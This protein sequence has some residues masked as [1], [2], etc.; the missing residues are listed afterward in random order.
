[1]KV[2]KREIGR[3][4]IRTEFNKDKQKY[5]FD[6]SCAYDSICREYLCEKLDLWNIINNIE[7][8]FRNVKFFPVSA[9]GHTASSGES[10]QY[11]PIGVIEP[12]AWIA[13]KVKAKNSRLL[14]SIKPNGE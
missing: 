12:V 7:A 13:D 1:V 4:K 3:A 8:S 9:M 6:E 10:A 2:V 14:N 5:R 11:E